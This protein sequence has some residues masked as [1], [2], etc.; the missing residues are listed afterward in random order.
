VILTN[1]LKGY[2]VNLN[3]YSNAAR[4]KVLVYGAPKSGK[5]ALVGKLAEHFT[6]HWF[7]LENG[8]KTLLNPAILAPEFRKNV[9][10]ITVPDHRLYPIAIDTVREIL[11]GGMKRICTA[12]GKVSCP[13]CAKDVT[14]KFSEIDLAKLGENDILV[15][16]SLSQLANSAMNKGIL[17]ELQKPGG[18]EYKKTFVDYGVQGALM[19]QVLSFI[20]VADINIV[21][22]SHELESESLEGREKIVPV[23]GTRNFS[24]TSAKYFDTVVHASVV[25]KQHRAFSSSTY[26]PTII[27]GS[28]L[29][30]DL[31]E[32]KGGEL[33]L[34]SLFR[35]G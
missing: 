10:V 20:Q 35:R 3:E 13:L 32:K 27:T 2:K 6:L 19:E 21:A 29:A 15:I 33:S 26:S 1:N 30:I 25:N 34:I 4:S 16:D 28:R 23:A 17:K 31:D 11:R 12:H 5:T 9:N 14:A 18:E 8:I 22:I 24:L 7:D